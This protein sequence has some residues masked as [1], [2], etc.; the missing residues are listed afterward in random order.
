MAELR[1]C[2]K[3]EAA[4][5]GS[6]IPNSPYGFCGRKQHWTDK[7]LF[8]AGVGV[9]VR[10]QEGQNSAERSTTYFWTAAGRGLKLSYLWIAAGRKL[11]ARSGKRV[12]SPLPPTSELLQVGEL[13]ARSGKRVSSPLP[14]TSELLQVGEL[15]AVHSGPHGQGPLR[16]PDLLHLVLQ[17]HERWPLSVQLRWHSGQT[18]CQLHHLPTETHLDIALFL[19]QL[20][21]DRDPPPPPP[22]PPRITL[23]F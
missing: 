19:A 8:S 3:V 7:L 13:E 21:V 11:E 2:V 18:R 20:P 12:S 17:A 4:V 10:S 22:P 23:C 6:P 1:S 15:E 9:E 5:L 16:P 14:P